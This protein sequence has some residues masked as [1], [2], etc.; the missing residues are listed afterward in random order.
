MFSK[1]VPLYLIWPLNGYPF[2]TIEKMDFSQLI[3]SDPFFREDTRTN[4]ITQGHIGR[5]YKYT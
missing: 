4:P 3:L 2:P 1:E 5:R